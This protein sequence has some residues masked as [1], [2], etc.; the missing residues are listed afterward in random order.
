MVM[1]TIKVKDTTTKMVAETTKVKCITMVEG[2]IKVTTIRLMETTLATE[3]AMD[4]AA[5]TFHDVGAVAD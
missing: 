3:T 4:I 2:T 5:G 1:E